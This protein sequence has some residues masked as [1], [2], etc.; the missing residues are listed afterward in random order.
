MLYMDLIIYT[1][2]VVAGQGG[3]GGEPGEGGPEPYGPESY[4]PASPYD[5]DEDDEEEDPYGG[6]QMPYPQP[7]PQS[8]SQPEYTG[9]QETEDSVEVRSPGINRMTRSIGKRPSR[10]MKNLQDV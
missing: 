6:Y 2:V 4:G 9:V 8:Y 5:D 10:S 3:Y 7:Y 1:L